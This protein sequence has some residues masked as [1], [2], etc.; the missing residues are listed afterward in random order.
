[1]NSLWSNQET[2][3]YDGD[4]VF[5][6]YTSRLLQIANALVTHMTR[7]GALAGGKVY[8]KR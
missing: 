3:Q 7:S 6:A 5:C 4:L 2:Y 1:M 8:H